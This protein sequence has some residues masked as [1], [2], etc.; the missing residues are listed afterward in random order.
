MGDQGE[1]NSEASLEK[2]AD[3]K[4]VVDASLETAAAQK[5]KKERL[6]TAG[7]LFLDNHDL[8]GWWDEQWTRWDGMCLYDS[9]ALHEWLSNAKQAEGQGLKQLQAKWLSVRDEKSKQLKAKR[10]RMASCT[11]FRRTAKRTAGKAGY[12]TSRFGKKSRCSTAPRPGR[13]QMWCVGRAAQ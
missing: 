10:A 5:K 2:D 1:K 12:W 7:A 8:I 4:T 11:A 13:A 9:L 6:Q 3:E